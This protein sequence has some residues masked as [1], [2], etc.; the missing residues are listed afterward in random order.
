VRNVLKKHLN[1]AI[2]LHEKITN[3]AMDKG[4][5]PAYDPA[6]LIKLNMQAADTVL[7]L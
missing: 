4:Y 2:S 6:Q 1:D 5:Y 7:K 3:Y